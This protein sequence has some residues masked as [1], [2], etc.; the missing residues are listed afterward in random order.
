MLITI[1]YDVYPTVSEE[2]KQLV[3]DDLHRDVPLT[4]LVGWMIVGSTRVNGRVVLEL[5]QVG[6]LISWKP[7]VEDLALVAQHILTNS[8]FLNRED[9]PKLEENLALCVGDLARYSN[10]LV[11]LLSAILGKL[12]DPNCTDRDLAEIRDRIEKQP[13]LTIALAAVP[14]ILRNHSHPL[15]LTATNLLSDLR[16]ALHLLDEVVKH[17]NNRSLRK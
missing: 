14:K 9:V 5:Q 7:I 10:D 15:G 17:T 1:D 2:A 12:G 6:S 13:K 8:R 16:K 11:I 4:D 3:T